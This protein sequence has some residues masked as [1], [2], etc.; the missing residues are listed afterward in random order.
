[1]CGASNGVVENNKCRHGAERRINMRLLRRCSEE[2]SHAGGVTDCMKV[3]AT[4]QSRRRIFD[5]STAVAT[6]KALPQLGR[7]FLP[8]KY[9]SQYIKLLYCTP[10]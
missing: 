8:D 4:S 5:V 3:E 1:V 10:E 2:L 9:S 6:Q 7:R